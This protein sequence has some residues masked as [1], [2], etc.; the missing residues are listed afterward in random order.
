MQYVYVLQCSDGL[1]YV[2]CASDLKE[3]M[4]RHL[5]GYVPATKLRLPASLVLYSAFTNKY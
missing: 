1:T 5:N 4:Q 3:R 2:G